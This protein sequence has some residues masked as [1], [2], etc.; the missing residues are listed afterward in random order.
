MNGIIDILVQLVIAFIGFAIGRFG[1]KYG[2]HLKAP[3]HW[4]YGLIFI[5]IGVIFYKNFWGISAI[6][7]GIGHFIS[8]LNDFLHLRFY[9]VDKPH[10]WKF[11][12]IK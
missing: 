12:S 5:I 1:D 9:S 7:F 3:H 6:S 8:D 11:W 10:E 2:G 4:I